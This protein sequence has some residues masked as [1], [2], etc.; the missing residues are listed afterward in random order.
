[1]DY[2]TTRDIVAALDARK[3]S[4]VELLARADRADRDS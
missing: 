4:A 3:V 1:V 2:P